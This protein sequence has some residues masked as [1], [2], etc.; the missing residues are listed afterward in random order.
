MSNHFY[1]TQDTTLDTFNFNDDNLF[2]G[3][4]DSCSNSLSLSRD[5]ATSHATQASTAGVDSID[6]A[7]PSQLDLSFPQELL[8]TATDLDTV[9]TDGGAMDLSWTPMGLP[10]GPDQSLKDKI[11]NALVRGD[12][13]RLFIP[14]DAFKTILSQQA[15]HGELISSFP[16]LPAQEVQKMATSITAS[17]QDLRLL[18]VFGVLVLLDK[19]ERV[20]DFLAQE[21]LTLPLLEFTSPCFSSWTQTDI[22]AFERM[23]WR[24]FSPVFYDMAKQ[25]DDYVDLGDK[26][27][28]PYIESWEN[29][30]QNHYKG[31]NSEVWKVK[32]HDAHHNFQN[33]QTAIP[34]NPYFAIKKLKSKDEEAFHREVRNLQRVHSADHPNLLSLL[35]TYKYRGSYHLVFPW[36]ESDLRR[37]W[38]STENPQQ[39]GK[40]DMRWLAN[41]CASIADAL[42]SVHAGAESWLKTTDDPAGQQRLMNKIGIH[43][44]I[45]PENIFIFSKGQK[46]KE[47]ASK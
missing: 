7:N 16:D 25:E 28:L 33:L 14:D 20:V 3:P 4:F 27:I 36:A 35:A 15:V 19:V 17:G 26:T 6:F 47:L 30:K 9:V 22:N 21:D 12:G 46:A 41:Q 45:K 11:N 44:D 38:Q 1:T 37:L 23:Q 2:F 31:G 8:P 18:R 32:I 13:G 29:Q 24:F 42:K 39:P 5:Q 10:D 34:N 40:D 43:G